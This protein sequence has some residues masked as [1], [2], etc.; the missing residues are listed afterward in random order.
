M[1]AVV[2]TVQD[3]RTA[4]EQLA[5]DLAGSLR[6]AKVNVENEPARR[7][8]GACETEEHDDGP[9]KSGYVVVGQSAD[10][11]AESR[12]RDGGDLVDHE[13]ARLTY[14]GHLVGVNRDA[15]QWSIG[16]VGRE[17]TDRDRSSCVEEIVLNDDNWSRFAGVAAARYSGPDLSALH[18]SSPSAS[19]NA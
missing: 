14:P 16:V 5:V 3:D 2:G 11:F 8:P 6:I 1:G 4:L 18:S 10:L 13:P 7:W 19:M 12:A 9:R 17:R 15:K